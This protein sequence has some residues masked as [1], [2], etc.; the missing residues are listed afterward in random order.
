MKALD[1][2]PLLPQLVSWRRDLHRHPELG[3]EEFRT[4]D[5]IL[6]ALRDLGLD[7]HVRCGTGV[8]AVVE[9]TG[10]GPT[11]LIRA[12]MDALPVTERSTHT[13][14]SVHPGKMH[15]CGHDAHVATLLGLA[16]TLVANRQQFRGRV[17][18]V[19]QPAE[20]GPGGALPLIEDGVLEGPRV[21]AA[22]GLHVWN[23][24]PVGTVGVRAGA[25]MATTD[26]FRIHIHGQGGHGALPHL[27]VDAIAV[28]G[29]LIP[30]LQT[31]V[32]RNVS[33][34]ASAVIT[35]GTIHG[36][37]RHNVIAHEV[38]IT[39]TARSF[40]PEVAELLPRRMHEI[41]EGIGRAM[42]A[43]I[44]VDY[45]R[46][47]PATVNDPAMTDLVR[48]AASRVVGAEQVVEVE[49]TMGGEDMAY[50]L[51]HVPGCYFFVGTANPENGLDRPHHHPEFDIDERGMAIGVR[52]FWETV[53]AYLG[54]VS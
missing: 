12:D 48:H 20:E 31:I 39:G 49:P 35:L 45:R 21:D 5:V 7:P 4:R 19:F 37:E 10:D 2:D 3:F 46:V 53:Q 40:L 52:V 18:L 1:L 51:Q 29:Q 16:R 38:T 11:L 22:V 33:P 17:K 24:L 15:A 23:H 30:A 28:A 25:F 50:F 36:G 14:V 42:G 41:A 13:Y 27:A 34:L 43:R 26:E 6:E 8:V 9:G 54:T 32:S 47:Y 44:E